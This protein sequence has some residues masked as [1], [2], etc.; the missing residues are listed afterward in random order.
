M[1]RYKKLQNF[2]FIWFIIL[3]CQR[4]WILSNFMTKDNLLC[5]FR[6]NLWKLRKCGTTIKEEE[7][8]V[9]EWTIYQR[10]DT[11]ADLMRA[12][13]TPECPF[14]FAIGRNTALENYYFNPFVGDTLYMTFLHQDIHV[15]PR[16]KGKSYRKREKKINFYNIII[17]HA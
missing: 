11:T 8:N 6:F 17:K 7:K 1:S 12:D 3:H 16:K 15:L 10:Q 13:S 9:K 14:C 2:I 5:T 4:K